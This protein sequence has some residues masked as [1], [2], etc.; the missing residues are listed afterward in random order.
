[1][2]RVDA[3][4]EAE[5]SPKGSTASLEAPWVDCYRRNGCSI[6]NSEVPGCGDATFKKRGRNV[7]DEP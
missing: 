6:F 4:Q 2:S 7:D 1:M 5:A 3:S